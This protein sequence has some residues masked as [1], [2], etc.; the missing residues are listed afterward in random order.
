[1]YQA[2]IQQIKHTITRIIRNYAIHAVL[3][4]LN[5]ELPFFWSTHFCKVRHRFY[6]V[7]TIIPTKDNRHLG[8]E[9]GCLMVISCQL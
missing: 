4:E 1:M 6:R 9:R 3:T 5:I 2:I 7:G 8:L